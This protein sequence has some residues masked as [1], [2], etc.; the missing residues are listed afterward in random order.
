MRDLEDMS[1]GMVYDL[2]IE[3]ANDSAEYDTIATQADFDK[4]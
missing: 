2:M 1:V 3:K 4:F